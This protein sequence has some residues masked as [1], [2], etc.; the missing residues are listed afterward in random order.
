MQKTIK[1]IIKKYTKIIILIGI[2][3]IINMYVATLPAKTIGNIVDLM[4]DMEANQQ[5]IITHIFY[6]LGIVITYLLCIARYRRGT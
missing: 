5:K 6:L 4:I 2:F 3:I 1:Q